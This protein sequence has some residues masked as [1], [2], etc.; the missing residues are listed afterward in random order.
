MLKYWKKVLQKNPSLR[1]W[2]TIEDHRQDT[3]TGQSELYPSIFQGSEMV[4]WNL[5]PTKMDSFA[6]KK[7]GEK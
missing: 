2:K 3:L 6:K 1:V 4:R 7:I 5:G